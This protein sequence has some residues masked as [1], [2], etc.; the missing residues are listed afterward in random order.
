MPAARTRSP[1]PLGTLVAGNY[2]FSF[3]NGQLTVTKAVLTS[4][5]T[6]VVT[7]GDPVPAYTFSVTG[8]QNGENSGTAA[9]YVAPT[10]DSDY[11]PT[12]V[13]HA[14][15][16][17]HQLR[18]RRGRQL[19]LR[20]TATALLTISPATLTVTANDQT[21]DYGSPTRRSTR[22]SRASITS[23]PGHLRRDRQP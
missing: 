7:Y 1:P 4:S 9:G 6:A 13:G 22:P 20:V 18:R 8:F 11:T 12:N 3:A 5:P 21:R 16:A 17:D 2:S 23:R 10:C 14:L 19:H 15:A